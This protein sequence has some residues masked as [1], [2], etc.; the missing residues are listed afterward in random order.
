MKHEG[1]F[2]VMYRNTV[3]SICFINQNN[4]LIQ[5]SI[6]IAGCSIKTNDIIQGNAFG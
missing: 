2:Y 6:Y 3:A 5:N 1:G 4:E